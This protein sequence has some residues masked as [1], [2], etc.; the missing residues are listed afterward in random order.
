LAGLR[1][2]H[3]DHLNTSREICNKAQQLVWRRP[4]QEPFG[5]SPSDENPSGLGVFEHPLRKSN[6]YA[7]KEYSPGIGRFPQSDPVG[8]S[9]V[10][11]TYLY[12]LASPLS[13]IDP[14][15]LRAVIQCGRCRGTAGPL[16]CSVDEDGVPGPS[17]N[18]NMGTNDPSITPG[19]PYGTNGP[20]PPDGYDVLNARSPAFGRVLPSPTDTGRAG[21]VVTPAGTMR[22]GIRIHQGNFSQGCL[23]TGGGQSGAGAERYVRELV[24]RNRN[25]GG[26]TLIIQEQDCG[27]STT[28]PTC[29]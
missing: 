10:V 9:A 4:P 29:R 8:L 3:A 27:C 17:F 25:T 7:D 5:D 1:R 26:T 18:T 19:D 14:D 12:A 16:S 28:P 6:Y 13:L 22:S 2:S 21:Q 20:L 11:N 23:T 15:G 24:T